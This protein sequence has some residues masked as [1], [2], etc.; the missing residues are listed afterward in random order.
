MLCINISVTSYRHHICGD[1]SSVLSDAS[2]AFFSLPSQIDNLVLTVDR[3]QKKLCN[4]ATDVRMHSVHIQK[5]TTNGNL[6]MEETKRM[7]PHRLGFF[8]IYK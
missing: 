8:H 7:A 2:R 6:D 1:G 4:R 3:D 5:E